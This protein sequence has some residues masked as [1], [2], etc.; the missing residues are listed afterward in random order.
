MP[1]AGLRFIRRVS[2]GEHHDRD[3]FGEYM[4]NPFVTIQELTY[5]A[6]FRFNLAG[7]RRS[8]N[9]NQVALNFYSFYS[10]SNSYY[11]GKDKAF[12]AINKSFPN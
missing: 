6:L 7:F 1:G 8:F 11:L 2:H 3:E 9:S 4:G 5:N 10:L 12:S